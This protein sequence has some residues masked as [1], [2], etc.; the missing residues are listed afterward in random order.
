MDSYRYLLDIA[1]I[2][3]CTKAFGIFSK[4]LQMPSVVGALI[5]GIVL[6][7]A[8]LNIVQPSSLITSLSE[9]G[10]IVIMFS[11]GLETSITDL[12]KAGP[13]AFVIALLGVL[14]PLGVGYLIGM[15]YNQGPD[16]WIENLFIGV[17]FTATSVGITVETLKEMGCMATESGNAILAAAVIDDVLGIIC[18]TLV[19]GLADKSVNVSVVLLKILGFFIF[20]IVVALIMHKVF[21]WWFS[22]DNNNGLQRYSIVSFAFAL[23]MAYCSEEFFGVADITGSFVAGLII[24]GTKQCS[25]VT[26]RIGTMSYMLITPIFFASIGLKLEP[27][28]FTWELVGLIVILCVAAVL[29]KIVGCGLGAL[30]CKYSKTQSLRI[31]CG[32]ISRGEVAL[33]VANKGMAMGILNSF[34]VTPILLCVVFTTVITPI[35]LKIVYRHKPGD[36]D[37]M[38]KETKLERREIKE[39]MANPMTDANVGA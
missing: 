33:I 4:K 20:S 31:G 3:L 2:L 30:M 19:T 18:L 34:F 26:K 37:F 5:A 14:V 38:K 22:H 13:K 12:K 6:G 35:F 36:P 23:I 15:I 21:A 7:P 25:Y 27:V 1:V 29:T 24:S 8:M 17:I 9:L 11:A 28:S 39:D 16:A 10:V 32:M